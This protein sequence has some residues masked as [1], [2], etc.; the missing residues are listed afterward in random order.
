MYQLLNQKRILNFIGT[1][2]YFDHKKNRFRSQD[3]MDIRKNEAFLL[4]DEKIRKLYASDFEKKSAIY[5]GK[6]PTFSEILREIHKNIG[7]L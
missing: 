7:R 2:E 1:K 5:F 6:Q 4:S 3:E